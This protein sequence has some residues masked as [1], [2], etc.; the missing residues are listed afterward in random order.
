MTLIAGVLCAAGG[1][2]ALHA[3]ETTRPTS[4]GRVVKAFDFEERDTNPLP[5]PFGWIRAQDD[6]AVPRVRPGFPLWNHAVLDYDTP[7]YAGIGSVKLPTNGGSTSLLLRHGELSIFPDADYLVSVRVRTQGLEHARARVVATL[8]D[9]QGAPIEDSRVA[10]RLV[11]TEGDWEQVAIEVE[12]LDPR[13]AYMQIELEL[14]QPEQ[15]PHDDR[16]EF[17]VWP[18]DYSGAAW[19]DNL[20]V[21]QLP[22]LEITTAE[23]GNIVVS[24][25]PPELSVLIRDLTGEDIRADL[26]IYDVH[27]HLVQRQTISDGSRR[28]ERE[29][30]PV[31]PGF[32]WYRA[33]LEVKVDGRLVGVRLLDYIWA[34]PGEREA[35]SGMFGIEIPLTNPKLLSAA[36]ALIRG[37]GVDRA[38]LRVWDTTTSM[39]DMQEGSAT[40]D[41]IESLLRSGEQLRFELARLP[42]PLANTLAVDPQQVLPAFH[43]PN[44]AWGQWGT[45]M[46]D[47]FGQRVRTWTFGDQPSEEPAGKLLGQLEDARA[48]LSGFVPG[49]TVSIAWPIDRPLPAALAIPGVQ[50]QIEDNFAVAPD[51]IGDLVAQWNA[52]R[53]TSDGTD[54]PPPR[55]GLTLSPLDRPAERNGAQTWTAL[56]SMARKA[57][58]FWWA[59]RSSDASASDFSLDLRDAWWIAPGKRGQ[60]M[61]A[62]EL[63][64]W[65]TLA[66]HLGGRDAIESLDL[67]PGVKMLVISPSTSGANSEPHATDQP[68]GGLVLWLDEPTLS[69]VVLSMPLGLSPVRVYDVLG[70]ESVVDPIA[71][72]NIGV[73]THDIAITRSPIIVEGVNT[74]LVRFLGSLRLTPDTLESSSGMHE[75]QIEIRNP[76]DVPI[77]GRVFIVEP[78]GYTGDAEDIDRSWEIVPRVLPFNLS[79]GESR[80]L[81]VELGYSLGEIAG[82]K[83]LVFDVELDADRNYPTMRVRREIELGLPSVQMTLTARRNDAGITVV[84][85]DVLNTLDVDQ[86]FEVIAIAPGEA[87]IRRSI[88]ALAPGQ[89]AERQF[90]FTRAKPGDEIVVVLLPRDTSTRLNKSVVVP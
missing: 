69:P 83:D 87:R 33:L 34:P 6:P 59:A 41:L 80:S 65:R 75:H 56:G 67:I 39:S 50:L 10:S 72:G 46:L 58:S 22:R 14:L 74:Q 73:P 9:Q 62:P 11:R 42:K 78:G 15:Q 54:A 57:I 81:P 23:P 20:I 71:R 77:S 12:G 13:A 89:H 64:V 5:V 35:P 88:N 45:T 51:A 90:A 70:N 37:A 60:V 2:R 49:P 29:I 55:L 8:L 25:T 48:S 32:G 27:D 38:M 30:L 84:S 31:L 61:P 76:W 36:P 85:A 17:R 43:D 3:Q 24:D 66:T 19:F 28:V 18:Q 40:F 86:Y 1:S 53:R 79:P 52:V 47:R 44:G 4:S 16:L 63:I 21:A 7:A 26:R 82:K 68:R